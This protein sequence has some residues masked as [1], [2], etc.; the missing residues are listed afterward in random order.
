M[1]RLF[2]VLAIASYALPAVAQDELDRSFA[3]EI[4]RPTLDADGFLTQEGT[5]TPGP[6][7]WN[8][9][10]H[11]HWA[12]APL[13]LSD[14]DT[15]DETDLVEHSLAMDYV[16]AIG[17]GKRLEVGL[18]LPVALSQEGDLAKIGGHELSSV[19]FG[20]LR[21][22]VKWSIIDNT[23]DGPGLAAILS[24]TAPIGDRE[25]FLGEASFTLDPRIA[26]DFKLLGIAIGANVG[27]RYRQEVSRLKNLRTGDEILLGAGLRAPVALRGKLALL[28]EIFGATAA[29]DPFGSGVTSPVEADGGLRLALGDILVQATGGLGIGTGYGTPA[30]RIGGGAT[31]APRTHDSDSD[32]LTDGSDMCPRIAEDM[33]DFEDGDGC[34][35][36]DNDADGVYDFEDR[37]P[38]EAAVRNRD[39]DGDGCTD[40]DR[41]SDG[42]LDEADDCPEEAEDRDEF[43]DSDGC[44]DP[45]ND[46]DAI[47]DASDQCPN[48]REDRPSEQDGCPDPDDDDD[49]IPDEQDRCPSDAEDRDQF[50]DED[51]CPDP[52]ND[53]DGVLDAADRCPD[54]LETINGVRDDDGCADRGGRALAALASGALALNGAIGFD[55]AGAPT[56]AAQRVLDQLAMVLIANQGVRILVTGPAG[57]GSADRAGAVKAY[58]SSRGV[59]TG[60]IDAAAAAEGATG[61]NATITVAPAPAAPAAPAAAPAPVPPAAPAPQ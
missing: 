53:H 33:D 43:Q 31:W 18:G 34:P 54:Q 14:P 40:P 7:L 12:Q 10:L 49:G 26:A 11:L 13:V 61:R 29:K 25:N 24:G 32:G 20:D 21:L 37:C 57:E 4:F 39:A 1:R 30:Y 8:V 5:R 52:D 19:G 36:S 17:I 44:P 27:Y 41:D 42:I 16:F 35:E 47:P 56:A 55:A 50:E 2:L 51:G 28:L 46:G 22:A 9:G 48:D 38:V 3:L 23:A 45:D 59:A 60:R 58:L 15:G 6:F